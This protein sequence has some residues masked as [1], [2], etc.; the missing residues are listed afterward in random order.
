VRH[1]GSVY[2]AS[3]PSELQL[4]EELHDINRHNHYA[5]ELMSPD[6]CRL[7]YP[8]LHPSYCMGGLFFPEEITIEPRTMIHRVIAYLQEQCA[9][10]YHPLSHVV[11][12]EAVSK[13]VRVEDTG[14]R[15]FTADK[16]I[17][18]SGREFKSLYPQLFFQS[19]IEVAKLHMMQTYPQRGTRL[20]GSILTGLTIRRYESF[21]ECPSYE[22]DPIVKTKMR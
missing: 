18:C 12:C 4:L 22:V 14:G 3:D 2:I 21:Q 6:A 16:V 20:P 19:G 8:A 17:I 5:S 15:S 13:G 11:T 7:R 1:Q 9:L 10:T